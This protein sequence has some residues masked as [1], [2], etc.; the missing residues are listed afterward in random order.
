[1]ASSMLK[2]SNPL[3][4]GVA[5]KTIYYVQTFSLPAGKRSLRLSADTPI[6]CKTAQEAIDKAQRLSESRLGVIA[7][8]QEYDEDTGEYG[9]FVLLA[10]Y[11]RVPPEA[12]GED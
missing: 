6:Q 12:I 9:K 1:M 8:S 11:G 5:V 3:F 7:A 4:E 2:Y 10:Q